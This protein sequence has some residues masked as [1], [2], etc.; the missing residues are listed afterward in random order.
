MVK[1]I[2]ATNNKDK[3]EQI[4]HALK[5]LW[6]K[7]DFLSL[8][9]INYNK[10][11]NENKKTFAGNSLLKAKQVC[12]DS[13]Y[14]TIAEDSGLCV[15]ALQGKPGIFTQRY[16]GANATRKQQ[17]TKILSEMKNVKEPFR[18]AYFISV[19]TC[20][21]PNGKFIQTRG[22]LMG[23]ISAKIININD[24]LTHDPIFIPNGYTI[25][26][27]KLNLKDKLKINHRGQAIRKLVDQLSKK[28]IGQ[29]V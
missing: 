9:D 20:F 5:P 26:M 17:L 18:T 28:E 10:P 15:D 19:V 8:S 7:Y 13:G 24:G 25:T 11:I 6:K 4:Y 1:I 2:I 21:F 29:I 23:K 27:S 12:L 3:F 14:I 22:K 16:A